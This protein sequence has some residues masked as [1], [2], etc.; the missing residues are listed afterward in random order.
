VAKKK[1]KINLYVDDK[2]PKPY[3]EFEIRFKYLKKKSSTEDIVK[4]INNIAFL[5]NKLNISVKPKTKK[6]YESWLVIAEE[7][8]QKKE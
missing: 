8:K 1:P 3:Y 2:Q 5:L 7:I 4:K 6:E